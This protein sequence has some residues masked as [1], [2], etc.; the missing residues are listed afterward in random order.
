M[1]FKLLLLALFRTGGTCTTL[2]SVQSV[3]IYSNEVI[4]LDVILSRWLLLCIQK[5]RTVLA[6]V[7]EYQKGTCITLEAVCLNFISKSAILRDS[8]LRAMVTFCPEAPEG[9]TVSGSGLKRLRRLGHSLKKYLFYVD[10]DR[11]T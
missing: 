11:N 5:I 9:L 3:M 7:S 1:Q 6:K 10:F 4:L 2:E 8:I